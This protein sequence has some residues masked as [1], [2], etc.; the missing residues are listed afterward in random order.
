MALN[1][2]ELKMVTTIHTPYGHYEQIPRNPGKPEGTKIMREVSIK[3]KINV[4]NYQE[5]WG[6][7]GD[8]KTSYTVYVVH[9]PGAKKYLRLDYDT[10]KIIAFLETC[11]LFKS[12]NTSTK[13]D[14]DE[15]Y[16]EAIRYYNE[17]C[18]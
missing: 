5:S 6:T 1:K 18:K 14:S 12:S 2:S 11:T 10:K 3:G 16:L 7:Y 13:N 15:R 17:N 8:N 4:Y 9:L